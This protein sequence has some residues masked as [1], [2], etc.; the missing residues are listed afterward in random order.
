VTSVRL[1][2][3]G[4]PTVLIEV[5][6]WR[7]LSDPTF[8]APGRTY[9]FGFGTSSTKVS[10]PAKTPDELAP[11]HVVLVSHDNHGDNLDDAGRDVL[12][13]AEVVVTTKKAA[14]RLAG[15]VRGLDPWE[16]TTLEAPGRD[17]IV[18]TATPC[19]HGPPLTRPI[20]GHVIGFAL[21]GA[22]RD[23]GVIWISGDT[24]LYPGVR[25]VASR[26]DVDIAVL[27][28]GAVKFPITGPIRYSM[29]AADGVA[30]CELVA[31]RVAVPVHF[32]GW[33]HFSEGRAALDRALEQA[34]PETR[35][36][37]RV[38]PFGEPVELAG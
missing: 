10:G 11:V 26:L 34:A 12:A 35:H 16:T 23:D 13:S 18:V 32:E 8:D 21:D 36:R 38:V 19:R 31:P 1:T 4:G 29:T 20:V 2:H 15:P 3:I 37:F 6:G 28:L 33:S 9:Q 22:G 14:G 27:H 24:V 25:E 7:I 17:P 30:L 5:G